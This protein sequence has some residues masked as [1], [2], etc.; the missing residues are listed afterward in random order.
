MWK[1]HF[2]TILNSSR[3][4]SNKPLVESMLTDKNNLFCERFT[5]SEVIDGLKGLKKGKSPGLDSIY[6]EHFKYSHDKISILL[7]LL[8]NAM[9]I[10][11]Y[12][13]SDAMDTIIVPIIKDKKGDCTDKDNY[14]PVAITCVISKILEL[15][16]LKR[17]ES[18][19]STTDNQFGFKPGLGTDTCMFSL[20]Q[21]IQYY[22]SLSS[23][24]YDASKAFDKIN[25][26]HLMVKLINCQVIIVR[27]L[28]FWHCMQSF[29][30]RWGD[31]ISS[32]FT[33]SNGVR[34]GG[35]VS[36]ILFNVFLNQLSVEL[37]QSKIGCS[38][39]SHVVNHLFYADDS[40]LLAPSSKALQ[41]LI[42]ICCETYSKRFELTY[43]VK[44]TKVMCF[45]PKNRSDLYIPRFTLNGVNLDIVSMYKYLGCILVDTLSDNKDIERQMKAIYARG[46]MLS[47]KFG[48]C[49]DDVKCKLFKAYC[50]TLYC[51]SV[52]SS[53]HVGTFNKL[54][55]SHNR[56]L[57]IFFKLE[58]QCSISMKCIDFNI[59]CFKVL[60]RKHTYSFRSRILLSDNV[61]V[62][63]ITSSLFFISSNVNKRWN[64]ILFTFHM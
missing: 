23:P 24:V 8:F 48:M 15:V 28:Y 18:A 58:R 21:I 9:L 42:H 5:P 39:N 51:S 62:N 20:K 13:P 2:N 43:N 29:V 22:Q 46:N 17:C 3:D 40:V 41:N 55:S 7:C 33:V 6:S 61:I 16:I 53:F 12:I 56:M 38:I 60:L 35:I 19:L 27:L 11:G 25:H 59:D 44:K 32:R 37:N 52:W 54:Q 4:N 14:R 30:T 31:C 34:Q 47:K 49:N 10:H 63:A 45:K 26:Y 36:P 64:D 1:D 57:R 50:S